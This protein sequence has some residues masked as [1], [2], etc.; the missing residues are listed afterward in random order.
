MQL[1]KPH[2]I[3]YKVLEEFMTFIKSLICY[4]LAGLAVILFWGT[5]VNIFGVFGGWVAGFSLVGPLWYFLHYKNFVAN[6]NGTVFIDMA[7]AIAV[8]TVTTSVINTK[9]NLVSS[10]L[11]SLPTFIILSLGA[12]FGIIF[13]IFIENKVIYKYRKKD[14]RG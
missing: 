12:V 6:K 3:S 4:F 8:G 13:S 2:L 9:T 5:L 7:L 10:I 11:D 14:S 1:I